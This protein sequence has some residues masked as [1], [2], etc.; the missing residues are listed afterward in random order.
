MGFRGQRFRACLPWRSLCSHSSR[1]LWS[2]HAS[3]PLLTLYAL[4]AS[5]SRRPRRPQYLLAGY[6]RHGREYRG[7]YV[8]CSSHYVHPLLH[9]LQGAGSFLQCPWDRAPGYSSQETTSSVANPFPRGLFYSAG[10][11]ACKPSPAH[12]NAVWRWMY[13]RG[14][15]GANGIDESH[16]R[17]RQEGIRCPL[18][19]G[20]GL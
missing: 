2:G 4:R 15:R 11:P 14:V 5:R 19:V 17:R 12:E 3:R 16:A 7:D 10:D 20:G 9:A 13:H 1:T 6:E 8:R 18:D